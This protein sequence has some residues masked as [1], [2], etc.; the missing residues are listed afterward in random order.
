MQVIN[1][2]AKNMDLTDP[3]RDF[4]NQKMTDLGKYTA[5]M[6]PAEIRVE[7]SKTT[8][9]QNKGEIFQATGTISVKGKVM[10]SENIDK[11][12][13]AAIDGMQHDAARQLR[14]YKEKNFS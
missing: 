10:R 8:R 2:T 5:K 9:G 1:I 4:V 11:D 3:I 7:V 12:L 14:R 13:Y 6:E